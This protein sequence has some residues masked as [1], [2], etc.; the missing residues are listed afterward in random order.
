MAFGQMPMGEHAPFADNAEPR[1]PVVLVLDTSGSMGG[2][3]IA[4]LNAGLQTFRD[5]IQADPLASQR[6]EVAIVT[7]GP[8]NELAGF[9]GAESFVAPTLDVTGDTPLGAAIEHALDMIEDRKRLY[10]DNG[11][12]YYRPWVLLITDGA[13]TDDWKAAARRVRD[14]TDRKAISFFAI[15]VQGAD[16]A[17]LAKISVKQPLVLRGL[18]F[19]ELFMWLSRSLSTVSGSRPE[20]ENIPLQNPAT[21][22]GWATV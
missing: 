17:T 16:M 5:E 2:E 7:F 18:M 8:V 1:C 15:G 19:R 12:K 4:E 6:V 13:P 11:I 10:R 21:P 9:C 3:P 14:A 20:D 22:Q